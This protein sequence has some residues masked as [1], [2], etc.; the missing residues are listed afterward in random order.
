MSEDSK[1]RW[2]IWGGFLSVLVLLA[3][4]GSL[5]YLSFDET[6]KE[7]TESSRIAE[8]TLKVVLADRNTASFRRYVQTYLETGDDSLLGRLDELDREALHELEDGLA[9]I[10]SAERRQGLERLRA[11]LTSFRARF[12]QAAALRTKKIAMLNDTDAIG[13]HCRTRLD[14]FGKAAHAEAAI[15]VPMET[16]MRSR[17]DVIR[18]E[19]HSTERWHQSGHE[20]AL[21]FLQQVKELQQLKDAGAGQPA[22]RQARLAEIVT[23]AE[24]FAASFEA[25]AAV[26]FQLETLTNEAMEV[27]GKEI[28][29]TSNAVRKLQTDRAE[30]ISQRV[31][32]H[33]AHAKLVIGVL[34]LFAIG[35]GIVCAIV[36]SR[37]VSRPIAEMATA[38]R[39]AEEIG[40]L[41]QLAAQDGDFRNRAPVEGRTGFVATIS[42]AVNQL[43][44]SVCAAFVTIGNDAGKVAMA[45]GDASGAVVEVNAGAA[46]QARSLEQVREAIRQSAEVITRVSGTAGTASAVADQA[47]GLANRGQITVAELAD[48]VEALTA[49]GRNVAQ[50]AQALGHIVTKTDLLAATAAVEAA[51]LG[52]HGHGFAAI[53]HQISALTGQA[54]DYA[55]RIVALLDAANRD[56]QAGLVVAGT[57]RRVIDDI[58]LRVVETDGLIRT[59]AEAMLAQQSAI[60]EIDA[61]ADSLARIG[62]HNVQAGE[63]ISQRLVDLRQLSEATTA[64]IAQFKIDR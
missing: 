13:L 24:N 20:L 44:D 19:A 43:F 40:E 55:A 29:S 28:S 38:A 3:G 1:V 2:W 61:T 52:E 6:V 15:S 48:L 32:D 4:V 31:G 34:T 59:I 26:A 51:R 23:L 30:E 56:L 39:V 35:L 11:L 33:L 64:T 36:V 62:E 63:Q 45:A 5:S 12:D 10:T 37:K 42:H 58:H 17:L 25:A 49:G 50:M 27:I 54:G 16:L 7:F 57:A 41:I 21:T 47:T 60:L 9:V 46:E 22:D 18:F 53:G 14:E 8:G